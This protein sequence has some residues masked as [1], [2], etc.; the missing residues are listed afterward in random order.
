MKQPY[1]I[2]IEIGFKHCDPAGIVFYPRYVEMLNDT[3]ESWFKHALGVDFAALH[4]TYRLGI[5]TVNLQ[6]D[7]RAPS[8]LGETLT[9]RLVVERIGKSSI[10]LTVSLHG[11]DAEASLRLS[12][13]IVL[14]T[15]DL[16]TMTSTEI[17]QRLREPMA[18]FLA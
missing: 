11:T 13:Q 4:G 7:F 9:S 18:S 15:T 2:S 8:R 6:C 10:T 12:A 3:V 1:E 5:P 16:N 17:P 14:V